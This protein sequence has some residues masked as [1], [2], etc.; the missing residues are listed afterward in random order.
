MIFLIILVSACGPRNKTVEL[1]RFENLLGQPDKEKLE[2]ASP[3]LYQESV[4]AYKKALEMHL[5]NEPEESAYYMTIANITWKTAEQR[6]EYLEYQVKLNDLNQ[7]LATAKEILTKALQRKE[8]LLSRDAEQK[9][10]INENKEGLVQ[11]LQALDQR[12][13]EAEK[14]GLNTLVPALYN[15][16]KTTITATR[17][18]FDANDV[19]SASRLAASAK[20]DVT[21]M[22][23]SAQPLLEEQK[24]L[25]DRENRLN[26][27]MASSARVESAQARMEDRGLVIAVHQLFQQGK[28]IKK[29]AYILEQIVSLIHE[30]PEFR[31]VVEGHSHTPKNPKQRLTISDQMAQAVLAYLREQL[32]NLNASALG[33]GDEVEFPGGGGPKMNDRIEIVFFKAP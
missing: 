6:S 16:A 4:N 21:Q 19:F 18:T 28:L 1:V 20:D 3:D 17:Q 24:K 10:A 5:D 12:M 23:N 30:F 11:T 2:K 8:E 25:K 31:M 26:L 29:Q 7:R 14:L 13:L 33:R 22:F 27:L 9:K 32:P 15:K